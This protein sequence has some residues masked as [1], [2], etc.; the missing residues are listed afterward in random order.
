M[1]ITTNF[2]QYGSHFCDTCRSICNWHQKWNQAINGLLGTDQVIKMNSER[3]ISTYRYVFSD[4]KEAWL[5]FC[6]SNPCK[7]QQSRASEGSDQAIKD[8]FH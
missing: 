3:L 5:H 4:T 7:I 2:S 8:D 6:P 1:T